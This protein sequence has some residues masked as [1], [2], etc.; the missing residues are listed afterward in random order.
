MPVGRLDSPPASSPDVTN[1]MGMSGLTSALGDSLKSKGGPPDLEQV[2]KD[3]PQGFLQVQ[4]QAIEKVA[5][6]M[7]SSS[8]AFAPFAMKALA[9]MREGLGKAMQSPPDAAGDQGQAQGNEVLSPST[10]GGG[11]GYEGHDMGVGSGFVG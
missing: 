8:R 1:Q 7:A 3:N 2:G 10:S 4:Y 5:Q 11:G 6:Q 9:I